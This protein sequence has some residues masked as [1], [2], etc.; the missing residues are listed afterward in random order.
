MSN[1]PLFPLRPALTALLLAALA[2]ATVAQSMDAL[3]AKLFDHP[4]LNAMRYGS[5]ASRERA[6]AAMGLPDPVVSVGINNFPIFDPS[7]DTFLP[8]NKAVGIRQ[9]IPN[10]S[11]RAAKSNEALQRAVENDA[12]TDMQFAQL[13]AALQVALIE[14]RR[15]EAQQVLAEARD[16]KYAELVG[17]VETE[18][19][20]G[21]PVVFR[22]AEID[23]ERAEVART[24]VELD[25]QMRQ[26]DAQ[27]I[28]LVGSVPVTE[29]PMLVAKDWAGDAQA[30]HLVR[31]ADKA[32]DV[33]D[34]G[35]DRAQADYKPNWGAQLTYQ[36]RDQGSGALG[37]NFAGDD[38]VSGTVT[39]TVPLWAEKRQ[40][41]ALRAAKADREAARARH[42]AAARTASA[43][44]ST[45]NATRRA[46]EESIA[47]LEQ[48]I[49]AIADQV[50]AQLTTYESGIGDY[51]PIIDGEI[52]VIALR[53]KIALEQSRRDSAI[54]RM[55]ALLVTS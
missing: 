36:Q 40:A 18:I 8:T 46:A 19:D 30:F 37:S 39:F 13:Q 43:Q 51:S 42:L 54:A 7:F 44:Y 29:A 14:K 49:D 1:S 2:P 5:D 52:A 47:V 55:N 12:A 26:V 16:A 41:P 53:A 33:A 38:W 35:V 17:I 11:G 45:Y 21:R 48:K 22:L 9:Q 25:G 32:I 34:A 31:V 24:L 20:A 15:I 50:A 6:Q 23:V 27:L 4:S 10:R 28:D 3:E